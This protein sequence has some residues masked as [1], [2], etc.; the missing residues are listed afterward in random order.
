TEQCQGKA[1]QCGRL[2]IARVQERSE[3]VRL[4]FRGQGRDRRGEGVVRT[5]S[6][7]VRSGSLRPERD[8]LAEDA[9]AVARDEEAQGNILKR[10]V[11]PAERVQ[12]LLA[13]LSAIAREQEDLKGIAAQGRRQVEVVDYRA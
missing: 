7:L 3:Q 6:E 8:P 13:A 2:G 12:G 9:Q 4:Y 5:A 10:K 11:V 1:R